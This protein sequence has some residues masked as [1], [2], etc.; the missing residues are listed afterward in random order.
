MPD[1]EYARSEYEE[2]S[3]FVHSED[4][5][6]NVPE[7]EA[8]NDARDTNGARAD[9]HTSQTSSASPDPNRTVSNSL[10]ISGSSQHFINHIDSVM[11]KVK[12]LAADT[13]WYRVLKH[14]TGVEVFAKKKVAMIGNQKTATVFKG[15]GL[16]KGYSPA[17]V[18][19]VIGSSKLW[20]EWY[21]DGNLVE[22][23][24]EEVSLTYMCM[25]AVLGTRTRDL[26]LVEKVE[27]TQ[28]G[29]IY[30]C[31]SS[32]D[33]P[34]VPP[35]PGRVRA[36]IELNGWVLEP[37]DL[38]SNGLTQPTSTIGTK[39][40]YYLQIDVKTFVPEAFSQRYLA[41]RP[42]CITKIDSYLQ[43]HGSP[44]HMEGIDESETHPHQGGLRKSF[45]RGFMS[46]NQLNTS[47]NSTR[48]TKARSFSSAITPSTP[49]EP[50]S[51]SVRSKRSHFISLGR[52]SK[53]SSRAL[54]TSASVPAIALNHPNSDSIPVPPLP[55]NGIQLS[56]SQHVHRDDDQ[57]LMIAHVGPEKSAPGFKALN[58]ALVEF[59]TER[60]DFS[61]NKQAWTRAKDSHT[62]H[63]IWY[64]PGPKTEG[65]ASLPTV[66]G[67]VTITSDR[68]LALTKEQ[69]LLTLMSHV[70]QRVWDAHFL[71]HGHSDPTS[72]LLKTE[73]GFDQATFISTMRGIYPYLP[74]RSLFCLDQMVVRRST[75][76]KEDSNLAKIILIQ[77]SS[78]ADEALL[79]HV[80]K[81]RLGS[82]EGLE[83]VLKDSLTAK[84]L[85]KIKLS[86]WMIETGKS[87]EEIK[88]SNLCRLE[89]HRQS[90]GVLPGFLEQIILAE[91][92]N[93][94]HRVA[95]FIQERGFF[96]GFVRWT[97]GEMVYLGDFGELDGTRELEWRFARK[98]RTAGEAILAAVTPGNADAQICWFQ[99]SSQMF[100]SGIELFLDPPE[101]AKAS[102]VKKM[103]NTI[104]L[105][106][107][108]S[109]S[110][111][112]IVSLR[113]KPIADVK[114]AYPGEVLWNG[115]A[116]V[117]EVYPPVRTSRRKPSSTIKP[118][119][120]I[121]DEV[122]NSDV[123]VP[124]S[125]VTHTGQ[126]SITNGTDRVMLPEIR[127]P[128]L[129]QSNT[130]SS[131][132]HKFSPTSLVCAGSDVSMTATD[133][134]QQFLVDSNVML[135]IT[136][137]LYFT[138]SQVLFLSICVG[139]AYVYGKFA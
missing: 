112:Q 93:R 68:R 8:E 41:K 132:H 88:L 3:E 59:E 108:L 43:K 25:Q 86:G 21:E 12:S 116:L 31:A 103:N 14:R 89:L 1:S 49:R 40:S 100:E 139:L 66:A 118:S 136:K 19:A 54:A 101:A 51:N 11:T 4:D 18:F 35:V 96:P 10:S 69:V 84:S 99:W 29:A 138:K 92:A 48:S 53:S 30:F 34:R 50:L 128:V 72:G 105:N 106:W 134:Q 46:I 20:D 113:A 129:D 70:A 95:Q 75:T 62:L 55:S 22:N 74:D 122:V 33:T 56:V 107:T 27:A 121:K 65:L 61:T 111:P 109:S 135:I 26:S 80:A 44:I 42:L 2:D 133:G 28:N 32:V 78:K 120:S 16:I 37:V 24:S 123:G 58:A 131:S 104:Q 110:L 73:N 6:E 23:L 45:N 60:G 38:S 137:D 82:T 36:H 119:R 52:S 91:I 102:R 79:E 127:T 114:Q 98:Q 77:C 81:D 130:L 39:V 97:E 85:S 125:S 17:S 5:G 63:K 71:A 94:P 126:L 7:S 47:P 76:K 57:V 124:E 67:E 83:S 13:T 117:E 90:A 87:R 15:E 9:D 115:Q 64:K